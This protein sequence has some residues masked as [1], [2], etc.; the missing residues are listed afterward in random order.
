[1]SLTV[2][3]AGDVRHPLDEVRLADYVRTHV[4]SFA[5]PLIVKQ[6]GHGQSNPTYLLQCG[7]SFRCV[8]RKQPHGKLLQSA[9]AIDREYRIMSVL[10]THG[11]VPVPRMF[12]YCADAGVI[13]T[14]FFLMEFVAGRVFKEPTLSELRPLERFGI[15]HGMCDVLA[16]VHRFPW[17][18]AGLSDFGVVDDYAARQVRRWK[19]QIDGGRPTLALAGVSECETIGTLGDWL[20][21]TAPDVEAALASRMPSTLVHG[22]FKLD[23]LIFHPTEPR[24]VAVIDWEL[25]TIGSP[26]AD[27]AHCCQAY[28]W[29]ADHWYVAG[30]AGAPL[31]RQGIPT[32]ADFVNGWCERV[33][34]PPVP[35][36]AWRFFVSLSF[37]RVCAITHGVHARAL[38]GNSSASADRAAFASMLSREFAELGHAIATEAADVGVPSAAPSIHPLDA[39][40]FA[41]S[42][43]GRDVYDRTRAFIAE[44]IVPNEA[45]WDDELAANTAAGRRWMPVSFVEDLKVRARAEGLWNLCLPDGEHGAQLSNLDYAPTAELT[46]RNAWCAEVFNCSAPD[47]GNMEILS[48]FGSPEQQTTWLMPLLNGVIRSCFAMTEPA[49]G[50]SDATNVQTHMARDGDELTINGNKW[51]VSGAGDPRC[52][53]VIVM[54]RVD[55]GGPDGDGTEPPPWRQQT[56]VLV[57]MDTPGVRVERML[58][59]FGYD[60]APHGHAELSF[61]D[62]RVPASNVILGIGRGFEI[63]QARLGPGRVHHCMRA[64][65]AAERALGALCVRA[66]SRRVFGSML[67]AKGGTEVAI[68][69][70]RMELEQ[71]RRRDALALLHPL[72]SR[73]ACVRAAPR[74]LFTR[75]LALHAPTDGESRASCRPPPKAG[76]APD[77]QGCPYDGHAGQ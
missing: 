26:L 16:R 35:P 24:V 18:A 43:R 21:T 38:Q 74:P 14:P 61:R 23:N 77:P 36:L 49:S 62:V 19:R 22:D 45:R 5:G 31:H 30:L 4:Q 42:T 34:L 69:E 37:F 71:V 66:K 64:I 73:L 65:G 32:E 7:P 63:A 28:R 33:R 51:W 44:H 48:R 68:A 53:L 52:K 60:D 13:G 58:T 70:S 27:V 41:F 56:M 40:P 10:R 50:C 57:P 2:D 39:L 25:S 3:E 76:K 59:V 54:G 1:M 72:R 67:A 46:G 8:L 29:P 12:A 9:H 6:F 11:G 15:Y 17:Q 75:R 55:G 47:S 20:E